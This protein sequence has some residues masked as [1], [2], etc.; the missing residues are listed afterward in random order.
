[1]RLF[2]GVLPQLTVKLRGTGDLFSYYSLVGLAGGSMRKKSLEDAA[3][4]TVII[5]SRPA[6]LIKY[7]K[8][9]T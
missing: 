8:S 3:I 4:S 6:R 7:M 9:R 2:S 1:M 5:I